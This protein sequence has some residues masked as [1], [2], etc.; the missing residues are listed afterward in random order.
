MRISAWHRW[1]L[2]LLLAAAPACSSNNTGEPTLPS[3]TAAPTATVAPTATAT[4]TASAAATAKPITPPRADASLIKRQLLFGNPDRTGVQ[5]SPDGKQLSFLAPRDGVMNVWVAPADKPSDAKPV[6]AEKE[7]GI[8]RYFWAE[9]GEYVLYMQDKGGD[10][11]FH[12]WAVDLKKGDV[13]DITPYDGAQA[14]VELLS[15]KHPDEVLVGINNRDKQY[16]DLYRINVKTAKAELVLQNDGYAGFVPDFD[17]VPRYGVKPGEGGSQDVFFVEKPAKAAKAKGKDDKGA[18]GDKPAPAP[19]LFTKIPYEDALTTDIAGFDASGKTLYVLDSRGRD[20]TALVTADEKSGATKVVAEDAKADVQSLLIDPKTKLIQA[21]GSIYERKSWIVVDKKIEPDLEALKK[22]ADGDFDVISRSHD[23]KKWI[24]AYVVSDGPVR[25]YLYDHDKKK[26]EFLFTNLA[27]LEKVKLAKMYPRVIKSRDGLD[28]VSYLTVPAATDPD[29]N[30]IP[31]KPGPMVL[32]VHG[33]PWAR[34]FWG[35]N[36]THQWL[37]NRGYSVLSVNYRGSSG[38][39]KKFINAANKEW[40]G[41]M[42]DDLI[43]AVN[44]AVD[45]KIADKSQVAIMGGSYG[46]YAT[47]VGL[48]FTPDTFACGVDIVGPSSLVTL[49]EHIPPYWMPFLPQLVNRVGDHR[50]E[51][52]KNFLLSRSPISRVDKIAK[53]LLIGQGKN[54]PRVKQSEADQIVKAMQDKGIP[55]TY[56]LYPDEGHGFNRPQNRTSFNAVAETFLAQCLKG[57]YEP[58]GDDFKGAS[59]TVPAGADQV[60]GL[61]D[62]LKAAGK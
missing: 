15:P 44:W 53:P 52:G 40:A 19:R 22:V 55:V 29:G 56:V 9:N 21:V 2:A 17:F 59:I 60:Y 32:F 49:L 28:L 34:D 11:N 50:T 26:A 6:T 39:G 1:T 35:L 58:V 8:R 31:D 57:P 42:H 14:Q 27:A 20:T 62:A 13:K 46:G 18:K 43:D 23:D 3:G 25:Y 5:L 47:L 38:F 24:V 7:R 12:V 37:A 30:G 45:Q 16:H 54:D 10:E 51:E 61:P 48:T 41:K 33:G 4:E 36:N